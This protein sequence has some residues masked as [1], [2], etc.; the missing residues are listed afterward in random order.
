VRMKTRAR[1]R[2]RKAPILVPASFRVNHFR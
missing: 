2:R 1:C